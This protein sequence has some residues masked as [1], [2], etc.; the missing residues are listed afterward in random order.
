[1][2]LV[3]ATGIYPPDHGGPATF[4]PQLAA[5]ALTRGW[6]VQVVTLSD[7]ITNVNSDFWPVTRI[8]RHQAKSLRLPRMVH[9]LANQLRRSDVLFSNGLFEES[10][11]AAR[12]TRT[13]WVTKFVGDPVWERH[14]NRNPNGPGLQEFHKM[15]LSPLPALQ[16]LLLIQALRT[17][18]CCLTPSLELKDLLTTWSV[19]EVHFVPNGVRIVPPMSRY[20]DIDVVTVCR[21]VPWKNLFNLIA[22]CQ[23]A[24]ASLHIVGDGPLKNELERFVIESAHRYPTIFHGSLDPAGVRAVVGRAKV[25]A[26]VSTYEGMSFSLLEAMSLEKPVIVGDTSGNSQIVINEENGLVVNPHD[27]PAIAEAIRMLLSNSDYAWNLAQAAYQRVKENYSL[28]ASLGKTL[29]LIEQSAL[30]RRL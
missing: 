8:F 13:P 27:V 2:R 20:T 19:P 24:G 10:A 9:S 6:E 16:R 4:V 26:L 18:S 30:G 12:L 11:I 3:I 17:A 5:R 28:E 1:M 14:R 15:R 29:D 22:A 25:F 7:D 23:M 21:L